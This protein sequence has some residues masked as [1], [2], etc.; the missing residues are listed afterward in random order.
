MNSWNLK[1]TFYNQ[2]RS[3]F[4]FNFVLN[5]EQKNLK[6]LLSQ[7]NLKNKSVLD[8]GAGA[9]T[10]LTLFS[11]AAKIV[12]LDSSK[13]MLLK[14]RKNHRANFVVSDGSRLSVKSD[15]FEV[16]SAIGLLEYQKYALQT[17]QEISRVTKK[18]GKIV[19]TFSPPHLLNFFRNL[20]GHR[21][22]FLRLS[23]FTELAAEVG[24][25]MEQHLESLIQIQVFL[26]KK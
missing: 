9:G 12:A 5:Q 8:I 23:S 26:V 22:F 1:A 10:T 20:L 7:I 3:L 4:P 16:T 25:T 2:A 6:R 17:L 15:S 24:F 18:G 11:E 14:A 19:V 21:L 13:K